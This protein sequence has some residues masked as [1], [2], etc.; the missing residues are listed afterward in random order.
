M[1]GT[2]PHAPGGGTSRARWPWHTPGSAWLEAA[3]LGRRRLESARY[4]L[5]G[6]VLLVRRRAWD[7]VGPFDPRY[8]MYAEDEDWQRR[9]LARGWRVRL[10]PEVS[11]EHA[12]G[13]S[14]HD[15]ERLRL[16]LHAATERYI[17]KWYGPVGWALYRAGVLTGVG[18]RLVVQQGP[19]RRSWAALGP[20]MSWGPTAPQ[21]RA[22]ALP[23]PPGPSGPVGG[24][25]RTRLGHRSRSRSGTISASSDTSEA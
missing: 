25:Q 9:A 21:R 4:F 13:R 16:R 17:R 6:A 3:G 7:E 15:P 19:R 23:G 20:C 14:E 2:G 11:A 24:G 10:C 5:G 18:V 8:F 22:G 12:G 1:R